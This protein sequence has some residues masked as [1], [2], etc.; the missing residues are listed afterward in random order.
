MFP[1]NN[2]V[3]SDFHKKKQFDLVRNANVSAA[4]FLCLWCEM[5]VFQCFSTFVSQLFHKETN[6]IP[7]TPVI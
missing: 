4:M 5:F 6:L 3:F 1:K 7:K 2:F